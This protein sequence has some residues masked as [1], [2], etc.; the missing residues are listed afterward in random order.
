MKSGRNVYAYARTARADGTE[1][2]VVS[3]PMYIHENREQITPN[4]IGI[5]QLMSIA[6]LVKSKSNVFF[7]LRFFP[8]T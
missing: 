6:E 1:S 4:F 7:Q 3:A 8:F 5:A 2:I